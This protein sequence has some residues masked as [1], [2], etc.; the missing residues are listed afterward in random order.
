[1]AATD[2]NNEAPIKDWRVKIVGYRDQPANP[3]DWFVDTPFVR[4]VAAV[5]AQLSAPNM[6]AS[7]G[8]DETESL[9]D[10]LFKLAMMEQAGARDAEDAGRW[11]ERGTSIRA[12]I[13]LTD[14]TFKT[15][16]TIP[17][18]AGGGVEDVKRIRLTLCSTPLPSARGIESNFGRGYGKTSTLSAAQ[19]LRSRASSVARGKRRRAASST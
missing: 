7:G 15:P 9:L 8:G 6:Q 1:M 16:M 11:R 13:F 12:I 3:S 19:A 14:A 2:P 18:A 10:A 17:E 5:Q 4:D